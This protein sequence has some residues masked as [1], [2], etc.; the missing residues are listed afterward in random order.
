MTEVFCEPLNALEIV[1]VSSPVTKKGLALSRQGGAIRL[2]LCLCLPLKLFSRHGGLQ[3]QAEP[4]W[5]L[6]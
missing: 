4:A 3:T 6:Y 2:N 5:F 1:T